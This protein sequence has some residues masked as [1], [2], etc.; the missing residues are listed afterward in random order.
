MGRLKRLLL[1]GVAIIAFTSLAL[2]QEAQN[3]FVPADTIQRQEIPSGPLLYGA[4]AFVWAAVV[5]Y[6]LIL[7]RRIAR[8]EHELGEINRKLG[9]RS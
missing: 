9:S 1:A 8:V 4:Y 2:A 6:A 5:V 7:W 3:Q